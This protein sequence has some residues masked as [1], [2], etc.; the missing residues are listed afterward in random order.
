MEIEEYDILFNRPKGIFQRWKVAPKSRI[1]S[2]SDLLLY[3]IDGKTDRIRSPIV[4]TI[5]WL[6][7]L[8]EGVELQQGQKVAVV[9]GCDHSVVMKDMC[10]DCGKN[11]RTY[12]SRD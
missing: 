8:S 6:A 5:L 10:A 12:E 1:T 11:L 2:G 4:G 7:D 9:A 3:S